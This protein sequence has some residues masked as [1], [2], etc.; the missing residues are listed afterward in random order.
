M[1]GLQP[2][3]LHKSAKLDG[4]NLPGIMTSAKNHGPR[5]VIG[6]DPMP[7]PNSQLMKFDS[8]RWLLIFSVTFCRK[9]PLSGVKRWQKRAALFCIFCSAFIMY[10]SRLEI[11]TRCRRR[12]G[13]KR[14]EEMSAD[15]RFDSCDE[16]HLVSLLNHSSPESSWT[17]ALHPACFQLSAYMLQLQRINYGAL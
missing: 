11:S 10:H 12:I 2:G 15:M 5:D 17:L 9:V 4:L 8:N 3:W 1:M 13:E 7:L 16:Y 14:R 6:P